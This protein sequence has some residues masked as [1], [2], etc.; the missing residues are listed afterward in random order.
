MGVVLKLGMWDATAHPVT[1]TCAKNLIRRKWFVAPG[2]SWYHGSKPVKGIRR[3]SQTVQSRRSLF[4]FKLPLHFQPGLGQ[5]KAALIC[6]RN[7]FLQCLICG[8]RVQL[9]SRFTQFFYAQ[10]LLHM[11]KQGSSQYKDLNLL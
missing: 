6:G 5:A 4:P 7:N 9:P 2:I 1:K 11:S 3:R 8:R 10:R